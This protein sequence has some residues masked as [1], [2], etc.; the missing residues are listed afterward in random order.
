MKEVPTPKSKQQMD[1]PDSLDC[2]IFF[3]RGCIG[4]FEFLFRPRWS[5]FFIRRLPVTDN[6][7][8]SE[9][10]STEA[11]LA[12]TSSIDSLCLLVFTPC[13]QGIVVLFC[14]A[15]LTLLDSPSISRLALL[16]SD[17]LS[18]ILQIFALSSAT[19]WKRLLMLLS[20]TSWILWRR[21]YANWL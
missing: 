10:L 12:S 9:T 6:D 3:S 11:L 16:R 19:T 18:D 13:S 4:D 14:L 2:F 5:T 8:C 15:A 1:V 17:S 20:G 21:R 7:R